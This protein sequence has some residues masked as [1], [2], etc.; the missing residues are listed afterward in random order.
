MGRY[1]R[2]KHLLS[3]FSLSPQFV[4]WRGCILLK[5]GLD[6]KFLED[7]DRT[8]PR[9]D[10]ESIANR[11]HITDFFVNPP[12]AAPPRLLYETGIL[13]RDTWQ[14]MLRLKFPDRLFEIY[15][16]FA[17]PIA[18]ITFYQIT[19]AERREQC[20]AIVHT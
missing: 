14:A 19:E 18:E 11:R 10:I 3:D 4:E 20:A 1:F 15:F 2:S 17:L 8:A 6:N 9:R 13:V 5:D 16:E 7:F 12:T